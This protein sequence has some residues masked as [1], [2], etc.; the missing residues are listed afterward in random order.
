MSISS[1]RRSVATALAWAANSI[2]LRG[3][4]HRRVEGAD[5]RSDCLELWAPSSGSLPPGTGP[6]AVLVWVSLVVADNGIVVASSPRLGSPILPL[7]ASGALSTA[8]PR[9]P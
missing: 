8:L 2:A 4:R 1:F 3:E 5:G 9:R 7:V 6:L